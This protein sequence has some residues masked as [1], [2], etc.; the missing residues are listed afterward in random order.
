MAAGQ[1]AAISKQFPLAPEA[2]GPATAIS[3]DVD[4]STDADA[5]LAI[6]HNQ[7]FPARP[8]GVIDLV[9]ISLTASGGKPVAFT[10]GD[11]TVGF[12]FSAG[13]TAGAAVFDD[14]QAAIKSLGL[15]ETPG[16]DLTIGAAAPA[17]R[18]ALLRA[19]YTAKAKVSGSHPIGA[20]G[21]LTFGA[22]AAAAGLTSVL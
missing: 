17:N 11:T 9:H 21:S 4:P 14:P 22:S 7:P 8:S 18:Y 2:L 5:L 13:V 19:G 10:G 6:A 15:D 16:L 12:S 1:P 3:L 20:I